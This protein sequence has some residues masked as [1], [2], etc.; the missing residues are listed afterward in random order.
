MLLIDISSLLLLG[1]CAS[2]PNE[3]MTSKNTIKKV[4]G[5]QKRVVFGASFIAPFLAIIESN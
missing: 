2:T 4:A 1:G 5:W 3:L